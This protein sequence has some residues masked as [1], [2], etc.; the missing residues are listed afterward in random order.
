[1]L[2][3]TNTSS[4]NIAANAPVIFNAVQLQKGCDEQFTP[5]SST[6]ILKKPGFYSV[7]FNATGSTSA[8]DG[9]MEL[10]LYNGTTPV[11]GA[12]AAVQSAA[13]A[14]LG[15]VSFSTIIQVKPSC[16]A[17]DNTVKLSV[18]S[19]GLAITLTEANLVVRN[20]RCC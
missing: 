8:T 3:A 20:T 15:N 16:C 17:V 10:Q 19:N 7:S 14:D 18:I 5:N 11:P 2:V 4:Q 13:P 9:N 6:V 1:M 12:L